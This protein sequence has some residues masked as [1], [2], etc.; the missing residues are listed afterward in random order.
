MTFRMTHKQII[1]AVSKSQGPML[2]SS[3]LS[4]PPQFELDS[5]AALTSCLGDILVRSWKNSSVKNF[6]CNWFWMEVKQLICKI[7]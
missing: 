1:I 4:K 5:E 6:E 3:L 7:L 2:P